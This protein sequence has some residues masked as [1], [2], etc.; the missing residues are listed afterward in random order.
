MRH[1]CRFVSATFA[2]ADIP[3]ASPARH[4][5]PYAGFYDVPPPV[6]NSRDGYNGSCQLVVLGLQLGC[7]SC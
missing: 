6:L 1:M 2:R 5:P 3:C 4:K 7:E